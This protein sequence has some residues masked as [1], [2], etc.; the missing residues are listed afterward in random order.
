M[1]CCP[2]RKRL[3]QP[4][5]VFSVMRCNGVMAIF[6]LP[7]SSHSPNASARSHFLTH[8]RRLLY[9]STL[10]L[11]QPESVLMKSFSL[12]LASL[13][14]RLAIAAVVLLMVWGVY[15]WAVSA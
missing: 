8:S 13:L 3:G 9:N 11:R 15:Y 5:N 7:Q 10:L 14:Q 12:L 1:R 4:E 2:L 6:R